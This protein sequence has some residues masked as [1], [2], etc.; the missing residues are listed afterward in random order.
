MNHR[1][2]FSYLNDPEAD[3][4]TNLSSFSLSTDTSVVKFHGDPFSDFYA[5][6][7]TDKQT[8]R[9]TYRQTNK[10]HYIISLPEVI[11]IN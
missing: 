8:D 2:H 6:L 4:F 10:G 1:F 5:K 3:K 11:N 9:K 7:L